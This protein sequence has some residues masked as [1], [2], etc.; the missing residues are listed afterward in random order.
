MSEVPYSE[1]SPVDNIDAIGIVFRM[2]D[3]TAQI[4]DEVKILARIS[5]CKD[6]CN[7]ACDYFGSGEVSLFPTTMIIVPIFFIMSKIYIRFLYSSSAAF[8]L[9]LFLFYF[10]Q[11]LIFICVRF[12]CQNQVC[13]GGKECACANSPP[14]IRG[15]DGRCYDW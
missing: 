14:W 2:N 3:R 11:K 13:N 7:G 4:L 15:P 8:F 5:R 10:F 9:F 1:A 12:F 6:G